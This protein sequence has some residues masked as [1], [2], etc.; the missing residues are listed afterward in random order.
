MVGISYEL[1]RI[2]G[3][4]DN[5][6][7]RIISAPGLYIQRLTTK[8]PDEK[9]IEVAIKAIKPV[10]RKTLRRTDGNGSPALFSHKEYF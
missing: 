2:A 4:Y 3:R 5:I 10:Y 8:E 9:Q 1:I 6:L 7:T